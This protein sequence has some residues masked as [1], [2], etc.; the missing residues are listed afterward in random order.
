MLT[1]KT[2]KSYQTSYFTQ[3]GNDDY[4]IG[5]VGSCGEFFGTSSS[6]AHLGITDTAITQ[7][8]ARLKNLFEGFSADGETQ[9]RK[10]AGVV[11]TYGTLLDKEGKT[12]TYE[13]PV[14]LSENEVQALRAN[15]KEDFSERLEALKDKDG[16]DIDASWIKTKGQYTQLVNPHTKRTVTA[17]RDYHLNKYEIAT[18]TSKTF[19]SKG[20]ITKLSI[21]AQN[22]LAQRGIDDLKNVVKIEKRGTRPGADLTFSA[23]KDVS[24]LWGLS[25]GKEKLLIENVHK[26]AVKEA[27]TYLQDYTYIRTG[28]AGKCDEKAEGSFATF[29]HGTS[30]AG[31]PQLHTHCV[32]LN[33]GVTKDGKSG[34]IDYGHTFKAQYAA[35]CVYQNAVRYRLNQLGYETKSIDHKEQT[36]PITVPLSVRLNGKSD[37]Y[38]QERLRYNQERKHVGASFEIEGISKDARRCFSKRTTAIKATLTGNESFKQRKAATL[39]TRPPKLA[40]EN[41]K[42]LTAT[43]KAEAQ[44]IGLTLSKVRR[45][46]V[47]VERA[48]APA[49]RP[50][51]LTKDEYRLVYRDALRTL[52]NKCYE[53]ATTYQVLAATQRASKG[54]LSTVELLRVS[55]NIEDKFMD[56]HNVHGKTRFTVNARAAVE[57]LNYRTTKEKLKD[58][59]FTGKR[60]LQNLRFVSYRNKAFALLVQGKLSHRQYSEIKKGKNLPKNKFLLACYYAT[61]RISRKHYKYRLTQLDR[62]KRGKWADKGERFISSRNLSRLRSLQR[63]ILFENEHSL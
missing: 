54:T 61:G 16:H 8:D 29:Q 59:H 56:V 20:D 26:E 4:Y 6:L 44:K 31:D 49:F 63:T 41:S 57:A 36:K 50:R 53:G 2:L 30:R 13:A 39:K 42:T 52:T 1:I 27:L 21:K 34:A 9:L 12:I 58:T 18:V 45:K 47:E 24:I 23:T 60:L 40:E 19:D 48:A 43:W 33:I 3:R 22:L 5:T 55:K 11:R 62:Q 38:I 32:S 25:E 28:K 51:I 35:D 10:G 17:Q 15:K 14:Y 7:N 37:E 46:Q